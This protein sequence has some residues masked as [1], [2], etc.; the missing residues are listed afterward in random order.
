MQLLHCIA[1]EPLKLF[2]RNCLLRL[3]W[4]FRHRSCRCK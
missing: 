2:G 1:D 3:L 4:N